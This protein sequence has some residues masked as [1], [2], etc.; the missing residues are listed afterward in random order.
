MAAL[1]ACGRGEP[2]EAAAA[3]RLSDRAL[4][5]TRLEADLRELTEGIGARPTGS[6][7]CERA[8]DWAAGKLRDL[9]LTVG[10]EPFEL[11]ALWLPGPATAHVVTPERAPL[12]VVALPFSQGTRGPLEGPLLD[13]GAGEPDAIRRLGPL[14]RGAVLLLGSP[15]G[16]ASPLDAGASPG[17]SELLAAA[18]GAGAAALLVESPSEA[19]LLPRHP[20]PTDG[21][22]APLP[23]ALLVRSDAARL[24]RHLS[25]GGVRVRLELTPRTGGPF[26]SRNVVATL[27]GRER[28]EETVLLAA[29]L[30][31][32]DGGT[33]ALDNAVNVALAIDVARGLVETGLVPRRSVGIV[34]FTGEEQGLRGSSAFVAR[35]RAELGRIAALVVWDLGAGRTWGLFTNRHERL[36]ALARAAL[37]VHPDFRKT[38]LLETVYAGTDDL[39]FLKEGV[40]CLVAMQD[41]TRYAVLRHTE[42][43]LLTEVDV[44]QARRNAALASVLVR[45]MAEDPGPPAGLLSGPALERV[46]RELPPHEGA[47]RESVS[48]P[49]PARASAPPPR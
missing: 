23:S 37:A 45:G 35:R 1:A 12:R 10:T 29:H 38:V 16:S 9:G 40:P 34:L 14:A 8:V 17:A 33:G 5:S 39:P 44:A 20:L 32:W 41:L 26:S 22:I 19:D 4:A 15:A 11:P 30:D 7:A 6:A 21:R 47:S 42:R 18:A 46:L 28:P 27:A 2:P 48:G 25:R 49:P 24:R 43:D 13:A 3:R 36:S 31:S